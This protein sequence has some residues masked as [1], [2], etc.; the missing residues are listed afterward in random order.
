[1][2]INKNFSDFLAPDNL[3]EIVDIGANPIDGDPPYK[4]MLAANLCRVVGFEPQLEA[5]EQL[6]KVKTDLELYLPY[7]IGT[8]IQKTLHRC[9][10]SGWTSLL[11]PDQAALEAFPGFRD[12][13]TVLEKIPVDPRHLDSISEIKNIDFL[14]LDVQGSELDC[15][16]SGIEKLASCVFIQ[17]EISFVTLYKNQPGFGEIDVFLRN[18]GFIPHCFTAIKKCIIAPLVLNNDPN[19]SFNQLLESDLVYVKN[20][21]Q[22]SNLTNEQLKQI[23]LVAHYCFGS[24]DLAARCVELLELREILPKDSV[25]HYVSMLRSS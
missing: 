14:K 6:N 3:T 12:N 7:V 8:G 11:E 17:L 24:F 4:G 2:S 5:L 9:R 10:Y 18:L 25:K 23:A 19:Q 16:K 20:F 22:P 15:L 13:A 1:M 21:I